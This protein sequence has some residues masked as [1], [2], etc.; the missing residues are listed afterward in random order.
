[1]IVSLKATIQPPV[2]FDFAKTYGD[3]GKGFIEVHHVVPLYSLEEETVPNPA[4]DTVKLNFKTGDHAFTHERFRN[5]KM[6]NDA[7]I[8]YIAAHDIWRAKQ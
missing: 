8:D 1:M 3:L 6:S 7:V 2:D 4:T 5:W